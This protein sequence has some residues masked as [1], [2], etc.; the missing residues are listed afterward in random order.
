MIKIAPS[1]LAADIL[2]LGE[3][4][5]DI[6]KCG[7]DLLHVDIMDGHFV[8]NLSFG[9]EVV[10]ALKKVT[11]LELDVHLMLSEPLN[12]ID[13]FSKAGAD[14]ITVHVEAES[15]TLEC[16]EKIHSYGVKAGVVF[17]PDTETEEYKG[18]LDKVE[19]A[20]VMS[21]YPGFGG[22]KFIERVLPKVSLIREIKG[23]KFDIEIDGGINAVNAALAV[24]AGANILVAGSAVFGSDNPAET[25][26][27]MRAV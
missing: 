27:A 8:P 4:I 16:I 23:D 15:N 9:P 11:D 22:Q 1:I 21:V 25:I 26:K 18:L 6:Q 17:N 20:L 2:R 14:I 3:E 10:K 24:K 7:A 12:Y 13:A 5:K 19:M